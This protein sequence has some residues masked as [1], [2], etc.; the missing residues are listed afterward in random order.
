MSI[1][2]KRRTAMAAV[3]GVTLAPLALAAGGQP[4]RAAAPMLGP[5]RPTFYRFRLGGF[6]VTT[7][8]DGSLQLDGPHPIF[9]QNQPPEAVHEL[10]EAN[11]LPPTRFVNS[12]TPVLVNTGSE[13]VLFDSGN[14]PG[15]RPNAGNLVDA[16]QA[17]GYDPGQIDVVVI[18]H[19]HGD[20]IG[21]LM[22]DGAPVYPNARYA[23]G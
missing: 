22:A 16:L 5:A 23:T 20:H 15:R 17:A 1:T 21:G 18:T 6:E 13:V 4:A 12:Y 7:L 19:M 11:F 8:L 3:G 10:A 9:G 2:I 14:A